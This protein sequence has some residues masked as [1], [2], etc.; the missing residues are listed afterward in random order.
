MLE[1]LIIWIVIEKVSA[2]TPNFINPWFCF[3]L[4]ELGNIF[5]FSNYLLLLGTDFDIAFGWWEKCG[6]CWCEKCGVWDLKK[7]GLLMEKMIKVWHLILEKMWFVEG[8]NV[9]F[10]SMFGWWRKCGGKEI[11]DEI[12]VMGFVSG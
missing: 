12:C 9:A 8:K 2:V 3:D 1:W 7:C 5:L 6:V 11:D 10:N 4:S